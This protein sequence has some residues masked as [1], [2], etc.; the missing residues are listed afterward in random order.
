M[1][2]LLPEICKNEGAFEPSAKASVVDAEE[3][4]V[5]IALVIVWPVNANDNELLV[6]DT[7][8]YAVQKLKVTSLC[9]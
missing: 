1:T 2:K 8:T 7:V 9:S 3:V 5:G 6:G 4:K